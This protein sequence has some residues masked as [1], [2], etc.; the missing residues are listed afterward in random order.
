[1]KSI[2]SLEGAFDY[3]GKLSDLARREELESIWEIINWK[4]IPKSG[5]VM[6]DD[7]ILLDFDLDY[8]TYKW[9]GR[10]YAWRNDFYEIEFNKISD[11]FTTKGW[12]GKRFLN[13]LIKRAPFITIAKESRSCGEEMKSNN[14]LKQLSTKFFGGAIV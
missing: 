2:S 9:R 10:S 3:Q 6:Q 14:I 4:H 11:Y 12:T 5:F 13:R 1:M 7:P 8:F